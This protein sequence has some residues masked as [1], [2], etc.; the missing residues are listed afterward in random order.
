[1]Y[2]VEIDDKGNY[3]TTWEMNNVWPTP[4]YTQITTLNINDGTM[5]LVCNVTY[6]TGISSP[7]A[8]DFANQIY[9]YA[10][11]WSTTS[12]QFFGTVD[13][14]TCAEKKISLATK[15]AGA[16]KNCEYFGWRGVTYY[17]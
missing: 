7:G 11:W 16:S 8:F 17:P 13:L 10:S 12:D 3:F 1:M 6:S 2:D 4:S 5:K 15:L 14:K 9:R